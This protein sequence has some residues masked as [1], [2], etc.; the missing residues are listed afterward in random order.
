MV[1]EIICRH[2]KMKRWEHTLME[3]SENF[4]ACINGGIENDVRLYWVLE[5]VANIR[6][7]TSTQFGIGG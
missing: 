1:D 7:E 2:L 6:V 5:V 4:H 3:N